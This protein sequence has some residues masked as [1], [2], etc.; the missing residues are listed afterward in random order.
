MIGMR[1]ERRRGSS[2]EKENKADEVHTPEAVARMI[3]WKGRLAVCAG[4]PTLYG[5]KNHTHRHTHT[6]E[7]QKGLEFKSRIATPT[8]EWPGV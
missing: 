3:A 8:L 2:D 1:R 5:E 4:R 6:H 7:P